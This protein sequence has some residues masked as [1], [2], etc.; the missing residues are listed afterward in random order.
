MKEFKVTVDFK[1]G[2][3]F[4]C[5]TVANDEQQARETAVDAARRCGFVAPVKQCQVVEGAPTA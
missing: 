4:S 5:N 2:P 1:R 3:S